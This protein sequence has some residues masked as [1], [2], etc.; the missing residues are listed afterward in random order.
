[1]SGHGGGQLHADAAGGLTAN[2][3]PA[4]LTVTAVNKSRIYGLTNPPLTA[5]YSGFVRSE[6]TNVLAGAPSLSTSA[7]TNSL[8]GTYAIVAGAGTLSAAN[9]IFAFIN[10]TLRCKRFTTGR[11]Y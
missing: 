10:G 7:T 4:T 8:P 6:G 9:Y 5:S 1:M 2:I 11:A 3:T